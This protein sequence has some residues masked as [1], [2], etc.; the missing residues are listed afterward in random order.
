V[1]YENTIPEVWFA[2]EELA[3]SNGFVRAPE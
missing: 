1:L 2:S 3:Q